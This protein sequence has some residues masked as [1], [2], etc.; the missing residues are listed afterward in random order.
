MKALKIIRILKK[1]GW[2]LSRTNGSHLHFRHPEITQL[3][4]LPFHGS[5]DLSL[6][7]LNSISKASGVSLR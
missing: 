4:T 1:N 5:K 2:I 6:N 3:V 7:I